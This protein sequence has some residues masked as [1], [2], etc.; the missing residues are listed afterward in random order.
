[1]IEI[2]K[3]LPWLAA[4]TAILSL[5]TT[6]WSVLSSPARKTA[7]R[8]NAF[9]TRLITLEREVAMLDARLDGLPTREM[10]HGL[11][12]S[13]TRLETQLGRIDE[14]LRPVAATMERM[15]DMLVA[16][17]PVRGSA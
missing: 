15:Q 12:L 11:E 8:L 14:R 13:L 2:V 10:L 1:M 5:A 9:E 4:A 16:R 6:V 7:E 3:L 17:G